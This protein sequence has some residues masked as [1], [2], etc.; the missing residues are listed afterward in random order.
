MGSGGEE[1]REREKETK[2]EKKTRALWGL[3]YT[4]LSGIKYPPA[5]YGK[6]PGE[7]HFPATD[8]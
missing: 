4:E 3:F 1:E 8:K 7:Q 2:V 5:Y 6:Q